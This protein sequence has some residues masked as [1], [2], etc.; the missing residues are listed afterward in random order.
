[1]KIP[2]LKH[3]Y[4]CMVARSGNS[5]IVSLSVLL[6]QQ[7][8]VGAYE[9]LTKRSTEGDTILH[10]A[11]RHGHEGVVKALMTLA[12]ALAAE[13]NHASVSPLYLAVVRKSVGAVKHCYSTH[14]H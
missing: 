2:G 13:V 14:T 1:M 7:S 3:H 8:G 10:E 4:T 6:A 5:H 12:P 9:V 11:A